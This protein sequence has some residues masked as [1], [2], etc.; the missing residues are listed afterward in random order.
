MATLDDVK[1][2]FVREQL[3][4]AEA[5]LDEGDYS[6]AVRRAA[7]AYEHLVAANPGLV[8]KP[9]SLGALPLTGR[10]TEVRQR[11]PWP[12]QLGVRLETGE[13]GVMRAVFD[14]ETFTLS[15]AVA[16]VEYTLDVAL[17]PSTSEPSAG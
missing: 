6:G 4:A 5:A 12:D 14:R 13:D 7:A 3:A 9:A 11:G 16:Y 10:R 1:D 2:P 17:H 8:V 15:E